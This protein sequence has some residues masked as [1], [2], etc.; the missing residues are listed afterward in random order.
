MGNVVQERRKR[1]LVTGASG[2][3]GWHACLFGRDSWR[4]FGVVHDHRIEMEGVCVVRADLTRPTQVKRLV[5]ETA[6]DAVLHLAAAS[7]PNLCQLEPEKTRRINVD[8]SLTLAGLASEGSIPYVFTSSDLVFDGRKAPYREE[9]PVSPVSA[10]GEQKAQAEAGILDR[11]PDAIICRM[12]L[13]FGDPRSTSQNILQSMIGTL[14]E[15]GE[16]RLFT[17]EYRTPLSVR[18]AVRGLFLALEKARGLLHL[19]GRERISR[20]DF[21]RLVAEILGQGDAGLVPCLQKDVPMAAARPPDVSLDSSRA[22]ALGF[23]PG[24]LRNELKHLLE[25][26]SFPSQRKR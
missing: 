17:D 15:G 21:G 16:L 18:D 7:Q 1:L 9:D 12:P 3:L 24:V 22:F 2:F 19:G 10:Y 8:A 14:R 13:L 4:V 5:Q 20:Y 25:G 11:H 6:P 26:Y 23:T